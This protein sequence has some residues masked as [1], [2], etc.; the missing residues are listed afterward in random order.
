MPIGIVVAEAPSGRITCANRYFKE[1]LYLPD[2]GVDSIRD[3]K[4]YSGFTPDGRRYQVHDWPL[5]RAVEKGETVLCEEIVMQM[6]DD[7]RRTVLVSAS[8][9]AGSGIQPTEAVVSFMDI[10]NWKEAEAARREA[11]LRFRAIA[12][13]GVVGV[14]DW[15]TSDGTIIAANDA[16]LQ[17]VG[18]TGEDIEKK[19]LSIFDLTPP[20]YREITEQ[21][22][23]AL[24]ESGVIHQL[25]KQYTRADGTLMDALISSAAVD[26]KHERVVQLVL[27]IS[28]R[29]HLEREE[30]DRHELERQLIGI[31]SHDL[32]SPLSAINVGISLLLRREDLEP[33]VRSI[34][35]NIQNSADRAN[36]MIHQLLDFTRARLGGG[37][38]IECKQ[39][40]LSSFLREVVD[41]VALSSPHRQISVDV[42]ADADVRW[43][44]DRMAQV[45]TNLLRNALSYSPEDTAVTVTA[46]AGAET[47]IKI[48]NW[49]EPIP[50]ELNSKLFEPLQRGPESA[51]AGV[52]LGLFIVKKIVE[53]HEGSVEVHSTAEEGIS[54][55]IFI[56][57]EGACG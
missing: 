32:R 46:R 45:L 52:G 54:I 16:F 15:C 57:S 25:R 22:V 7:S 14:L 56:P 20:E 24:R 21:K 9:I 28:E 6:P 42:Q 4:M 17:M 41:E 18:V 27:D 3:Y 50:A 55:T 2:Q 19:R 30:A 48:H 37:I 26:E 53:A 47:A 43:D 33:R 8:R 12:E 11:E 10:S 29:R 51:G 13:S 49:G 34:I 31:V 23:A 35:S 36:R 40:R 39:V 44:P 38:P 1:H 5:A